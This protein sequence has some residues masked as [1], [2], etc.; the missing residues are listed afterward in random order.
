MGAKVTI[1]DQGLEAL[2]KR[3]QAASK[4]RLTVGVHEDDGAQTY[5]GGQTV[6]EV[7]SYNELGLGVPRRSF[8]ADWVDESEAEKRGDLQDV[9]AGIMTGKDAASGMTSLGNRYVGQVLD[10]MSATQPDDPKTV[11]EK[12]SSE[13]LDDSGKLRSAIKSRVTSGTAKP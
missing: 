8:I 11:E 12:G 9:A 2:K 3:L 1:K 7:A 4:V 13:P 10:R 6:A 5:P